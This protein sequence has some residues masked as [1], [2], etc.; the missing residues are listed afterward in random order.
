VLSKQPSQWMF[1]NIVK[2]IH[3]ELLLGNVGS[4]LVELAACWAI[5]LIM[6]GLYLWWPRGQKGWGGVFYP[7]LKKEGRL[8]WRDLHAVMGVWV[9]FFALFLLITGLPWALVWGGALKQVRAIDFSQAQ[10][11]SPGRAQEHLH[12]RAQATDAYHLTSSVVF[13]VSQLK[14]APPV[15]LSLANAESNQWKASSQSQNRPLRAEIWLNAQGQIQKQTHFSDKPFLDRAIG[16]GVAA[17]EGYLFGWVNL[18]LGVFT[19]IALIVIS[20]S[21]TVMWY[22]R[23]PAQHLGAPSP[24]PTH[25]GAVFLVLILVLAFFLPLLGMSLAALLLLEFLVLKRVPSVRRWLGLRA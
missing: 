12:G 7:R 2:T 10:D 4:I 21:G 8:F 5:V 17:H 22:S 11:W 19:C 18:V 24:L 1:M 3:G 14:M 6:T 9:S 25:L 23:K 20:V 15:E 16:I 13:A